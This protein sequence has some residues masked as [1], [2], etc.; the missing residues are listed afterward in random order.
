[1]LEIKKPFAGQCD[2][3]KAT[4]KRSKCERNVTN[5]ET[6]NQKRKELTKKRRKKVTP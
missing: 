6:E 3:L 5:V 4:K 1:M 2:G